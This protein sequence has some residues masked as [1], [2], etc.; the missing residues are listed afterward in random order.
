MSKVVRAAII[1]YGGAF[2]MGPHHT[3]EM[4]ATGRMK[5]VA[6][7]DVD[8]K[9]TEAAKEDWPDIETFNS[10]DDL[11]KWD[12]FDLGVVILPHNLH[13]PVCIQLS[14]AGKHVVVE[15]PMCITTEEA[16]K[17]IRAAEKTDT[18]LT[19]YHNRRHDGDFKTLKQI[20]ESGAIGD[21]Y[22]VEMG[23]MGYGKPGKWWRSEKKISGGAFYDWGAHF[24]DWL[25]QIM[26]HKIQNVTG[27]Y[28][29][30]LVWKDV[31]NE[32]HV[33]A[34]I[35][36]DNNTMA[37]VTMS[38]IARVGKPRWTVLGTKGAIV[39]TGDGPDKGFKI[40]GTLEGGYQG[41]TFVKNGPG[42]HPDYYKNVAEAILD[43]KDID[44]KPEE[45]RRVIEI[46]DYAE[47]SADAGAA[48]E[49]PF[50]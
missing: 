47:R 34:I 15:K 17:M 5:L 32:D 20:I 31:S 37:D 48:M 19:V 6:V 40:Y 3:R 41:E 36:F 33:R 11:L 9:R 27:F 45:A 44:V 50:K 43:G 30:D 13:A 26:P 46:L 25:L 23:A 38:S 14:E 7:C 28:Q 18:I 21:V 22:S 24:L 39:S 12:Q 8:K 10:V 42:S 2:N 49:I 1:G 29:K 35:R 4:H 16:T